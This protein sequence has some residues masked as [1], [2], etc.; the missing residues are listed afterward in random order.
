MA[1]N[2]TRWQRLSETPEHRKAREDTQRKAAKHMRD[3]VSR[4]KREASLRLKANQEPQPEPKTGVV[5]NTPVILSDG[6]AKALTPTMLTI[7]QGHDAAG[8][9]TQFVTDNVYLTREDVVKLAGMFGLE[10][11][12]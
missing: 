6:F 7:G 9:K 10:V 12:P 11:K 5:P 4:R 1:T 2:W 3:V 8:R